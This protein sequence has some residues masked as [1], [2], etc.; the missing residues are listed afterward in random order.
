VTEVRRN[1]PLG[2]PRPQPSRLDA[3]FWDAAREGR[4]AVQRCSACGSHRFPPTESCY[5]CQSMDSTWHTL[6]G[7]GTV[8]SFVWLC[9]P[10]GLANAGE[11]PYNVALVQ[12]DGTQGEPV[13]MLSNV[14]DAWVVDDLAVGQAVHLECVDV[15]D[16]VLPCFRCSPSVDA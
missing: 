8:A 5:A 16:A 2:M 7:T 4:L 9:Q 3:G 10:P 14:V 15:G 12:L 11:G 13:R 1:L 6:P